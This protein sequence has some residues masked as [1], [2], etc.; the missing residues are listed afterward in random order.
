MKNLETTPEVME[1]AERIYDLSGDPRN[2]SLIAQILPKL[3][4]AL[5]TQSRTMNKRRELGI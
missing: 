5:D 3:K 4:K 2:N 1:L